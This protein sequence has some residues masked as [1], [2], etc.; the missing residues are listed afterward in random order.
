[1]TIRFTVAIDL[2]ILTSILQIFQFKSIYDKYL[3]QLLANTRWA[4]ALEP[5]TAE[6]VDIVLPFEKDDVLEILKRPQPTWWCAKNLSLEEMPQGWF[7]PDLVRMLPKKPRI[8]VRDRDNST[9]EDD[10][11][12][13]KNA[14]V[15][16]IPAVASATS[17]QKRSRSETA[18]LKAQNAAKQAMVEW[19]KENLRPDEMKTVAAKGIFSLHKKVEPAV[20]EDLVGAKLRFSEVRSACS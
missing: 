7:C 6:S 9:S 20:V 10:A 1:M 17:L 11:G 5:N 18:A 12:G 19:C 8:I 16:Q 3:Q 2:L 13:H 14:A 15:E 4:L